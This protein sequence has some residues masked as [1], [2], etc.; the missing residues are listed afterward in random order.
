VSFFLEANGSSASLRLYVSNK[1]QTGSGPPCPAT[2]QQ[3]VPMSSR[4]WLPC[5][6]TWTPTLNVTCGVTVRG[7]TL[8][9]NN[10][11]A[12]GITSVFT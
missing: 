7:F 5:P 2:N 6:H 12:L 3:V 1:G 10:G 8:Q 9:K 4:I 11:L